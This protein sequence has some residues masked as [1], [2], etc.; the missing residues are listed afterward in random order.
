MISY[1]SLYNFCNYFN[2]WFCFLKFASLVGIPIGITSSAI[3]FKICA[4]TAVIKKY[5]SIINK[6]KNFNC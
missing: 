3:G 4:I 6:N 1:F 5:Q 2:F